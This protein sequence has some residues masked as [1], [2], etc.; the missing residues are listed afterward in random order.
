[1]IHCKNRKQK[2]KLYLQK[3]LGNIILHIQAK[4]LK[5]RMKTQVAYSIWKKNTTG[6]PDRRHGIG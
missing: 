2:S 1:M 4:Y 3:I 6:R 5:D